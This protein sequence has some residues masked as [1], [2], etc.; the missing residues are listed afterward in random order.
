MKQLFRA[1][2]ACAG[3]LLQIG[4]RQWLSEF[5]FFSLPQTP[6]LEIDADA[7]SRPAMRFCAFQ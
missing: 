3:T 2:E 4:I 6:I 1:C 5:G 7:D